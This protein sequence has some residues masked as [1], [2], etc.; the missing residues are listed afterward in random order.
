MFYTYFILPSFTE[1]DDSLLRSFLVKMLSPFLY[2]VIFIIIKK[3][4]VVICI[5]RLDRTPP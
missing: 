3:G 4:P 1:L 5:Q 2:L